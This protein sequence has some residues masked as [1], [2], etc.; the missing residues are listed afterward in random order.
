MA[1]PRL[2]QLLNLSEEDR[3]HI[4]DAQ[5]L[6]GDEPEKCGLAKG[7]FWGRIREDLV[8]PFPRPPA[9]EEA[10][11]RPILE[12]LESYLE[13]EHPH[14]QIDAEQEIPAW[15]LRRLFD[16]GVMGLVVPPEYGGGGFSFTTYCRAL[17]RVGRVCASTAV[18]ISAH[19]S[20]GCYGLTL[21]GTE[22]QKKRHL[23]RVATDTLSAFCLSEPN[24]GSDAA[25]QETWC[26]LSEDGKY[27]ILEGEK[28]W[29]TSGALAGVWIVTAKER[30]RAGASSPNAGKVTALICTPD[31]PGVEIF[32]RNRS[33]CGIRGTWQARVRFH[34]VRVPRDQVLHREGEGLKVA[35]SCLNYGRCTLAASILGSARAATE[36]ACK[37]ARYRHQFGRPLH[38]F[39]QIEEKIARLSAYGYA[40]DSMLYLTTGL[41]D[42]QEEDI[43]LETA[44]CKVFCSELGFRTV[45]EALQIMGGE[46]YM[47]ENVVE[48]MW[49]DS[50]I[51]LIVEG[52]NEVMNSF[53]FAYGSKQ[54]A[55]HLL[56][57]RQNVIGNLPEALRIAA[58]LWLGL[59]RRLPRLRRLHPSLKHLGCQVER[60]VRDFSHQILCM[61]DAH[62]EKLIQRQMIQ[63]RLGWAA[64]WI[65]AMLASLSKLDASL[66]G[67]VSESES[68]DEI[69]TVEHVCALGCDE[70]RR[71]FRA[72]RE[73]PD[74][75][76]GPAADVALRAADSLPNSNYVIPEKTPVE[77]ARGSGRKPSPDG[78]PSFGVGIQKF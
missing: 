63:A 46:G 50:R 13:K 28:K 48:R 35:L 43:M 58:E 15:C 73:N 36:Q 56:D 53:V 16:L 17:E 10:R 60:I 14:F 69:R 7:F 51:H 33:K 62:R 18:V 42:R 44:M 57:V 76:L 1:K 78:I 55:E 11:G 61:Y 67:A 5:E 68:A 24:V 52:A 59:P 66:R 30:A 39:E 71:A 23:S 31:L 27:Y 3:K 20:I 2:G 21:F 45:H 8:F 29:A 72:L 65:Y 25:G 75:T 40:M 34:G 4:E 64:L 22:E 12:A 54:F 26:E 9:E 19:Q 32:S 70:V 37:W 49:R 38:D 41:L 77:D 6:L 47:T 74:A